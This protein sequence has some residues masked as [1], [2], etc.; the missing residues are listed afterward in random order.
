LANALASLASPDG[1][2]PP[3]SATSR[4]PPQVANARD[5]YSQ[6][7]C[8]AHKPCTSFSILCTRHCSK[9]R[10]CFCVIPSQRGAGPGRRHALAARP[11]G[12]PGAAARAVAARRAASERGA[13]PGAGEEAAAASVRGVRCNAQYTCSCRTRSSGRAHACVRRRAASPVHDAH[14]CVCVR[15]VPR[16][17]F[18]CWCW[19]RRGRSWARR[20]WG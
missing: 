4:G 11:A 16:V 10:A 1:R 9:P 19:T 8:L 20:A 14:G 15:R 2:P 6:E 3:R 18:G 7:L 13:A 12:L 5:L 17:R